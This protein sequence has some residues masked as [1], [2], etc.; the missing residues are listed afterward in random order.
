MSLKYSCHC[1][2]VAKHVVAAPRAEN[3]SRCRLSRKPKYV[4]ALSLS[5]NEKIVTCPALII[6]VLIFSSSFL[7]VLFPLFHFLSSVLLTSYPLFSYFLLISLLIL[8]PYPRSLSTLLILSSYPFFSSSFIILLSSSLLILSSNPFF[9]SSH[10]ILS[11]HPLFSSSLLCLSSD[12]IM[13]PPPP[14]L[15]SSILPIYTVLI[16]QNST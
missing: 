8:P 2:V 15:L 10:V 13:L 9:S 14:H 3:L 5:R 16:S 7:L 11:S 12:L 1:R 4:V 6:S